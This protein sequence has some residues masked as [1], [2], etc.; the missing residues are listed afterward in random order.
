MDTTPSLGLLER[1]REL[2]ED[3][4]AFADACT[5]P[6][7]WCAWTNTLRTDAATAHMWLERAGIDAQPLAWR[8]DAF[9][10]QPGEMTSPGNTLAYMAG[11]IH[12]QEEVSL[13][14]SHLLAPQPGERVI[15]L[16]AAPGGKTM[17]IAVQMGGTGTVVANDRDVFRLKAMRTLIDRLGVPNIAMM[18]WDATTMP[19]RT[20]PFDRVLADVP[21]SGEGT[22]R[23][24][25]PILRMEQPRHA[26]EVLA[27]IQRGVLTRAMRLVKPGGRVIYSTCTFAPEENEQVLDAVL[28]ELGPE[29]MRIVPITA[30]GLVTSPGITR[31][32]GQELDASCAH[33]IR[34]WPHLQDTGGFFVAMLERPVTSV[35]D[36]EVVDG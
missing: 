7:P 31:W 33:A 1:Y 5:R 13:L 16:C 24:N 36:E 8:A 9:R 17:H 6:L 3:W 22:C 30:P 15:D 4:P 23:K 11:L 19:L 28:R 34:L 27:R 21:C 2:V 12:L 29:R 25:K 18:G 10:W 32:Q 35:T 26:Y 20:G 14:A